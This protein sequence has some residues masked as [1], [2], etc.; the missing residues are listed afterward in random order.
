MILDITIICV[1]LAVAICLVVLEVF[2]LPGITIAGFSSLL[3]YGGAIYFAYIQ[4]GATCG[5]ITIAASVVLTLLALYIFMRSGVLQ[6]FALHTDIESVV[7]TTIDSRIVPGSHG[8]ALSRLNP[9]G[10]VCIEGIKVEGRTRQGFIDE[11]TPV[12]VE[13]IE[14]T[15][16]IVRPETAE[17]TK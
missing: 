14:R 1:L 11:Q 4:F 3:F 13:R 5:G 8:V 12:V 7:P 16:V 15:T 6:K 2:F 9:T 17:E 10:T